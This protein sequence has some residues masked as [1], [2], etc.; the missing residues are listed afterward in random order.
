MM[1]KFLILFLLLIGFLGN[2]QTDNSLYKL[3]IKKGKFVKTGSIS[4]LEVPVT[5]TNNA[6]DTLYYMSTSCSWQS[7]YSVKSS[8]EIIKVEELPCE[9]DGPVRIALAPGKSEMVHLKLF[10]AAG[11]KSKSVTYTIGFNLVILPGDHLWINDWTQYRKVK[12]IIWSN[13]IETDL[14]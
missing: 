5:L 8:P 12:N 2:A 3:S 1:R 13:D 14:K 6:K 9:K 11:S 7:L 10:I 4:Y